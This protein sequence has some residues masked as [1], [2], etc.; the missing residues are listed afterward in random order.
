MRKKDFPILKDI[1]YLDS[2]ATSQ[3]PKAVINAIVDYYENYNANVHRGVYSISER[4]TQAYEDAHTKVAKFINAEFEEIIFT[5]NTTESINMVMHDLKKC[6]NPGDEILVSR[7]E[8]HSNLV[9]WQQLAKERRAHIRYIE[10]DKEGNLKIPTFKKN[11]KIVALNHVSN[12]L[13]TINPI[14]KITKLAH[15]NRCIV[16]L[17]AAQSVPHMPVDVKKL[18]IDFMAFSGH[19]MLGPTGIGVL[20]GK[21]KL[22]EKMEPLIY[23]GDMIREV[24][25]KDATWNDL[26]WK[27]EA[28][29]PNIAGGIG[30]GAAI[31]YLNSV[32]MK[33]IKKHSEELAKY[34]Y[35]KLSKMQGVQV[36]GP[37]KRIGLVSFNI[38]EVHPHDAAAILDKSKIMVRAGHHCAMPLANYMKFEWSLRASF[39]LYNDKKEI[40]LLCEGIKK[41]QK[42]L[43]SAN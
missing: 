35:D 21:K 41:V 16:V 20:Y 33:N 37:K 38:K 29:T 40:D 3:K 13:G 7:V 42:V 24:T 11:T 27:F 23:G 17:D 34:A 36:Y 1:I 5:K 15:K 39:Y 32:G 22:L 43:Q 6:I 9:P 25:Y 31:D 2:A 26:P 4:A 30:L 10:I 12:V 8:H 19:K 18:D 28:G 14:E